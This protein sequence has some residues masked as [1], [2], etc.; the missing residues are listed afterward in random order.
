MLR[1]RWSPWLAAPGLFLVCVLFYW[2]LVLT[3]EYVW[4]N[5]PDMA[6]LELPRLQFQAREFHEGRFPLWD[7]YQWMGQPLVGQMQPGPLYPSNIILCLLP[8][9]DGYLDARWLNWY[10]VVTRFLAALCAYALCRDLRRSRTASWLAACAFTFGGVIGNMAWL[11]VVNGAVWTPAICLYFLRAVRGVRPWRNAALC[12]AFLGLAWLSGH[13]EIPTLVSYALAGGWLYAMWKRGLALAPRAA[14][15]FAIAMLVAAVQLWPAWEYARLSRRWAGMPEPSYWNEAIPYRVPAHY[16]WPAR[17]V[18]G[19][20]VHDPV[21]H[22][23]STAFVGVVVSAMAAYALA[24]RWRFPVVRW[25]AALAAVAVVFAL[26]ASTP[27]HGLLYS[28]APLLGKARIPVRSIHLYNFALVTLAAYGVDAVLARRHSRWLPRLVI[29]TGV[30]GAVVLTAALWRTNAGNAFVIG[31]LAALVLA[32]CLHLWTVDR[33]RRTALSAALLLLV[34]VELYPV[35]T[36]HFISQFEEDPR[37]P[38]KALAANLDVVEFL[39]REPAPRRLVVNDQDIPLNFGDWHGF[40]VMEGFS[41]A[42]TAN[43]LAFERH[44]PAVQDLFGVTH[45]VGRQPTR[46]GQEEVFTGAS[47]I[48]VFRNPGALPRVWSAHEAVAVRDARDANS[49]LVAPGFDARRTVLIPGVAPRLEACGGDTAVVASSAPN[50]VRIQ[51]RMNCR[52]VVTLSDA[53][54][55]GWRAT[56]DGRETEIL[57][58][59]GALRGVVVDGGEHTIEYVYRP[60]PVVG[61]AALTVLGMLLVV[62]IS[63][64]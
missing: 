47:G 30:V 33:M 57:P 10:F 25:M 27:L 59:Y 11:D 60:L 51:V 54:Y 43:V 52:G 35:S 34:A 64:L 58:A 37:A 28:F 29:A 40:D 56:V 61:G 13:H 6:Y 1:S 4:F 38:A 24:T 42:A 32:I 15:T 39:R 5:H 48:K 16:S 62:A 18:L 26:G 21:L 36:G 2:K 17:G 7:P 49:R 63:R 9:K 8:L 19:T 22:A 14:L 12:G 31:G 23:D 20:F 53:W 45:Y 46:P 3:S 41:A 50:R 55:P 44:R